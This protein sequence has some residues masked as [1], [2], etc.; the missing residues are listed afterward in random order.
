IEGFGGMHVRFVQSRVLLPVVCG[1]VFKFTDCTIFTSRLASVGLAVVGIATLFLLM[2]NWFGYKQA[3]GICLAVIVHPWFFRVSR[4]ARPEI[5]YL[6][7]GVLL[8]LLLNHY[9]E[10]GFRRSCFFAGIVV[11]LSALTHPTGAVFAGC[12]GLSWIIWFRG[13]SLVRLF[14]WGGTGFVLTIVP[15]LIYLFFALKNP[16]VS[17][18]EQMQVEMLQQSMIF[19]E[20]RRWKNFFEFPRLVPLG[21]LMFISWLVAW[22][23]SSRKDKALATVTA[24][25][26]LALPLISVNHYPRYL[27]AIVPFS[28]AL[29]AR[30]F[31]RLIASVKPGREG[32]AKLQPVAAAA[33]L[34][35]FFANCLWA[36]GKFFYCLRGADFSRVIEKVAA[37][38]EPDALVFADPILWYG[39]EKYNYGPYFISY[40]GRHFQEIIKWFREHN[41]KYAVRTSW[42]LAPPLGSGKVPMKMPDFRQK[43]VHD[44]VCK[45]FGKKVA[46]FEDPYYGAF[47]VYELNMGK[48]VFIW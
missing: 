39:R 11:G 17:F 41:F 12:V 43:V 25:L 9:F 40:E 1:T 24:L 21:I 27:S 26:P 28:T 2:E 29:I 46:S 16:E 37:V 4:R 6:A 15:Y 33:V 13:R 42:Y 44:Q 36:T 22:Y 19:T 20:L 18:R 23:D 32:F 45:M 48:R 35:I 30:L 3:F 47:E 5:Y 34:I 7:L 8:L 14:L 38:V 31:F 10:K